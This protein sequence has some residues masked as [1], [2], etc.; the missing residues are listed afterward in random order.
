MITELYNFAPGSYV[1]ADE[2]NGNF[3]ALYK[4]NVA[5]EE[6]IQDCYD[7]YAFPYSD[8][9]DVFNAVNNKPNSHFVEGNSITVHAEQEYYKTLASGQNIN[10]TIPTNMNG[11][12]RVLIQIQE[13]RTILPFV[14]NYSGTSIINYGFY[15][16]NYFRAGYYYIMIHEMNGIAQVKLIWTGV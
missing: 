14:I 10:I 2:W 9:T 4:I 6:T 3:S 12:C 8:L 13:L 16:Y 11:E 7:I 15:N 5:H 1:V